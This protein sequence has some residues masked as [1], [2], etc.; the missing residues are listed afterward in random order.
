MLWE[1][2]ECSSSSTAVQVVQRHAA[3]DVNLNKFHVKNFPIQEDFPLLEG[4]NGPL[5]GAP[6]GLQYI[7]L[8]QGLLLQGRNRE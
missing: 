6:Q 3:I 8:L 5:D 2:V 7:G 1:A 4:T